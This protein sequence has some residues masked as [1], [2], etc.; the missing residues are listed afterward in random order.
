MKVYVNIHDRAGNVTGRKVVNAEVLKERKR[1]VLVR[2]P[3]GKVVVRKRGR[4]V[5]NA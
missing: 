4:D 5:P 3:G 2:L 1:T